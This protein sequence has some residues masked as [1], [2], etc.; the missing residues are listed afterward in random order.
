MADASREQGR[1]EASIRAYLKLVKEA[2]GRVTKPSCN[3]PF[4]VAGRYA[5]ALQSCEGAVSLGLATER[6]PT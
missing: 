3:K 6:R 2:A 4:F 5:G 1:H